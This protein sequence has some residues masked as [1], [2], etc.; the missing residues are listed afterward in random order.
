MDQTLGERFAALLALPDARI[1]LDE[2]A[3]I[4]A[5][6]A[7]PKLD[8]DAELAGL[9]AIADQVR[10][11]TLTGVQRLL[12]RDLGFDGNRDDYYDPRNS[13]LDQVVRRRTG[14]PITLSVLTI[15]IARRVSVPLWGV[16]M[17]GH[18]LVRDKV[19]PNVFVDPFNRGRPLDPTTCAK[20]FRQ[21]HGP[22]ARFDPSFLEP[23]DRASII[24]R[25]LTNLR[26]IFTKNHDVISLAWVL[27]L[28]AE[29]P[30]SEADAEEARRSAA[31]LRARLN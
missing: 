16:G 17:P 1:P 4:I 19:D 15:E 6:H 22:F 10:D 7:D 8:I 14:I 27:D 30:G 26:G 9:D 28:V 31:L 21:I 24:A 3:F 11:P 13:F 29:L 12:F 5:A 23:V 25:M 18:F 2:A 20:V